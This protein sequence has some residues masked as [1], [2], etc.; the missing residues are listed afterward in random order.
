[1]DGDFKIGVV[2]L[3]YVGL[4]LAVA[5]S[6]KYETTG[7]DINPERVQELNTGIDTTR[8]VENEALQK[9]L[10]NPNSS[11]RLVLSDDIA[12]ITGCNVYIITVP[13]PITEYKTPDLS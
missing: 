13:T 6:E 3:G 10:G 4:P 7:F 8:E 5:F 12:S 11:R 2:G 9:A 1:M